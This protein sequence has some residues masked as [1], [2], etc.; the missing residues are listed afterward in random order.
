MAVTCIC[1][2]PEEHHATGED[3]WPVGTCLTCACDRYVAVSCSSCGHATDGHAD[4]TGV[5][6]YPGCLCEA[7]Q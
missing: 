7:A 4:R 1:G 5:C 3:L 6:G 2:C